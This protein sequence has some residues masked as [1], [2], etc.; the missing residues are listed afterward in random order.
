MYKDAFRELGL[1]EMSVS[2]L[3]KFA[4]ML[5]EKHVA[6]SGNGS[7]A[8]TSPHTSSPNCQATSSSDG[9]S[10][11]I[12]PYQKELG[13]L[14]MEI[15]TQLIF[16]NM[17]NAKIFRELG[18]A[19]IA[20]NMVPY[21]L[22]RS[23]ALTIVST[24]LLT[25]A[26]EDD[27]STLLGLMHTAEMEDLELKNAVL[28]SLLNTL[29]ESHRT[30]TVFRKAGGFVY[31]VS[32]LISMEG[33]LST[34]ARP[35]WDRAQKVQVFTILKTILNTLTVSMRYEPAN[36]KFFETE[37]KWRSLCAALKLL[38]CFD[39][40]RTQF[41]AAS[42]VDF[43]KR[44][45]DVFETFFCNLNE[46]SFNAGGSSSAVMPSLSDL[47]QQQVSD[48]AGLASQNCLNDEKLIFVCYIMRFLYDTA[49]DTFDK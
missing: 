26:G 17:A 9:T 36:A 16:H 22:C 7:E 43:V 2:C 35:P 31:V 14:I 10:L 23:Q 40:S 12:D 8:A 25:T 30:R 37:V 21:R 5:K 47:A 18:G 15:V 13:F 48:S 38:G 27:M 46:G 32:V 3:Q 42:S 29:R 6:S 11:Q 20:H 19:R 39:V 28:R 45:Y 1:L 49:L 44:S 33:A 34:P 41:E 4:N 24:L